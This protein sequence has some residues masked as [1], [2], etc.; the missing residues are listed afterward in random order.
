MSRLVLVTGGNRGIGLELCRQ[1]SARGD[2]VILG[3]RRLDSGEAAAASV[4]GS[5][6]IIAKQLD[7]TNADD[8]AA[9]A[10]WLD[11][12]YG[13][14]DVLINNAAI[15]Y[16]THQNVINAD[17]AEVRDTFETNIFGAWAMIQAMLPLLRKGHSPRIVNVSSGA[18]ELASMT[19][20]TPAYSL[21][22]LG[23][24]G[25]TMMF[26]SRLRGDGILVNAVCPGWVATDMGGSGGRPVHLGARSVLYAVDLPDGGPTGGFFR[27]GKRIDW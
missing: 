3:S 12:E 4:A 27:D 9:V 13:R 25:L 18:G 2:T 6:A 19:G 7:V 21:S 26:A 10:A 20:G 24:N 16:D 23:L 22:K 8:S 11:A 14:L 17:L 5:G 1:L 15:N